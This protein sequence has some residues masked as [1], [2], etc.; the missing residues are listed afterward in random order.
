MRDAHCRVVERIHEVVGGN[1]VGADDHVVAEQRVLPADLAAH[2]VVDHDLALVGDRKPDRR[3]ATLG[4][5]RGALGLAESPALA[6]VHRGQPRRDR[7]L[8]LGVELLGGAVAAVGRALGEHRVDG[9]HVHGSSLRLQ[10]RGVRA[11]DA[12]PLVPVEAAP[13]QRALDLLDRL[14]VLALLVGVL[15]AQHERAA[16]S[17]GV[18]PVVQGRPDPADVEE[19]RRGRAE[20]D[21]RSHGKLSL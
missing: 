4:L 9:R 20:A 15:D 8:S 5:E 17:P 12:R 19:S 21:A 14:G 7:G 2:D 10:V 16:T 3:P 1:A 6:R 18:Q 13:A 11:A